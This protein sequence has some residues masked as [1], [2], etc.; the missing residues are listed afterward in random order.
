MRQLANI[1][2]CNPSNIHLS[3]LKPTGRAHGPEQIPP[4]AACKTGSRPLPLASD[5]CLPALHATESGVLSTGSIEA[6]LPLALS[7]SSPGFLSGIEAA[8]E[9]K[10]Q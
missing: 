3:T 4:C 9:D 2:V 5:I 6:S 10:R 1:G 7:E 8:R